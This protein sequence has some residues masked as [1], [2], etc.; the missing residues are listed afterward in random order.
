[1]SR[2]KLYSRREITSRVRQLA[3]DIASDSEKGEPLLAVC[4]IK[5]AVLFYADLVRG[6][7]G[8]DVRFAF[9]SASSYKTDG[10]RMVS[11]GTV[12]MNTARYPSKR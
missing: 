12:D 10:E 5:G 6:I 8:R 2:R 11:G 7:K 4:V 3:K 9:V 1:M